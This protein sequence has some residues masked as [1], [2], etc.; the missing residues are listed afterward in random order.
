MR[1]PHPMQ[2]ALVQP[3]S[4]AAGEPETLLAE[5]LCGLHRRSGPVEG[6]KDQAH[7]SLYFR[8]RIE[9]QNAVV[10]IDQTD[11]RPHLKLA[12]PCFVDYSAS[13]SG[14]EEVQFRLRHSPLQSEQEPVVEVCRIIDSI[15]IENERAG[16]RTQLDQP[17]PV[18]GVPGQARDLQPHHQACLAK[19]DLTDQ[20]LKPVPAGRLCTRLT[21]I[22]VEYVNTFKRPAQRDR[23]ITQGILALRALRILQDLARCG[24][25]NVEI[26]I[27]RQMLLGNFQFR[28]AENPPV[29]C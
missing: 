28:H 16:Q 14:F 6:L 13:H 24:L 20:F 5:Q 17:M 11:R 25:S 29:E 9:N 15:L 22:A 2:L 10:P 19:G 3:L 18:C 12:A 21:E 26:S 4:N 23:A 8:V 7:R 1:R 27:V